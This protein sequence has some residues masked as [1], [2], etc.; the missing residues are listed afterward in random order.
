[1][2]RTYAGAVCEEPQLKGRMHIGAVE[3]PH[4]GAGAELRSPPPEEEGAAETACDG[5]T[6]TPIARC[7]APL[8][9]SR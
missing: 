5:L 4:A 9:G 6:T 3:G 2:G 8:G 7:P 1:M